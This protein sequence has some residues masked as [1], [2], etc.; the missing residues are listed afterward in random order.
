MEW[1]SQL[2]GPKFGSRPKRS[3]AS[4]PQHQL[5]QKATVAH[6]SGPVG[7]TCPAR[8]MATPSPAGGSRSPCR[9]RMGS[10]WSGGYEKYEDVVH[11]HQISP[12]MANDEWQRSYDLLQRCW[13]EAKGKVLGSEAPRTLLACWCGRRRGSWGRSQV[14]A[15]EPT[16][17]ADDDIVLSLVIDRQQG[18]RGQWGAQLCFLHMNRT[19]SWK[20]MLKTAKTR[21]SGLANPMIPFHPDRW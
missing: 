18:E 1:E 6:G 10:K 19:R 4:G 5:G 12:W 13:I 17:M 15:A 14:T 9:T 7:P 8:V 16:T 11:L 3:R 2:S 20:L 21:Q